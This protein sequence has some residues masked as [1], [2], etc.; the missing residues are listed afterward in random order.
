MIPEEKTGGTAINNGDMINVLSGNPLEVPADGEA[1]WVYVLFQ[2]YPGRWRV[3]GA[4]IVDK[5]DFVST[6]AY[7]TQSQGWEDGWVTGSDVPLLG[8]NLPGEP[9]AASVS[10]DAL[11]RDRLVAAYRQKMRGNPTG[12]SEDLPVH[13]VR[14]RLRGHSTTGGKTL[15][16]FARVGVEPPLAAFPAGVTGVTLF[17]DNVN[18]ISYPSYSG[19]WLHVRYVAP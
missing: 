16:A 2:S 18:R 6:S 5:P 12:Y 11:L 15:L 19:A 17:G 13:V 3:V 10:Q 1:R 14:Y 9:A 8:E 4:R 7:V